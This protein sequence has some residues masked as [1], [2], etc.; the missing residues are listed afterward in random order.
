MFMQ[1]VASA[2]QFFDF[3]GPAG[4]SF[5]VGMTAATIAWYSLHTGAAVN[6]RNKRI[7]VISGC[8]TRYDALSVTRTGIA[9][10]I[11]KHD[12]DIGSEKDAELP[13]S[14][15][16]EIELYYRRYWG[17]KS[18]QLDYW[19]AGYVDPE[20]LI[21]W[22]MSTIDAIH[23]PIEPFD[24]YSANSAGWDQVKLFHQTTNKRLYQ[25][26]EAI[27]HPDV[28]GMEP[29]KQ[30]AYLFQIFH[31]IE[32]KERG[33]INMLKRNRNSR[34]KM[35]TFRANL[36]PDVTKELIPHEL[37]AMMPEALSQAK[38]Q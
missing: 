22:F 29:P 35:E 10:E 16:Q 32:E 24:K 34:L 11:A 37:V 13:K 6:L 38:K 1:V 31:L 33:L 18:D 17:L 12:S 9:K 14:I 36:D 28:N 4:V 27:S 21:S 15:E 30:Y 7:D 19:L 5:C 2:T 25:I 3:L 20:T 8:N 23:N 26:V